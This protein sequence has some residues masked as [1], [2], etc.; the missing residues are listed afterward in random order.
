[1]CPTTT[2]VEKLKPLP[3]LPDYGPNSVEVE[4]LTFAYNMSSAGSSTGGKNPPVLKNLNLKLATG[5]R[6]LIIG[7]NGSGKSI[8]WRDT[9]FGNQEN[10]PDSHNDSPFYC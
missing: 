8:V 10:E 5:S 6:C 9:F 2:T 1:M 4:D 3:S 7:A